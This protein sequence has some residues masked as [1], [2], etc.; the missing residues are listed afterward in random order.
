MGQWGEGAFAS[1]PPSGVTEAGP[2]GAEAHRLL[3]SLGPGLAPEAACRLAW[4]CSEL[5]PHRGLSSLRA[6][7][8]A[9]GSEGESLGCFLGLG[10]K[11][12]HV[13]PGAEGKLVQPLSPGRAVALSPGGPL[14]PVGLSGASFPPMLRASWTL[15]DPVRASSSSGRRREREDR[16]PT[17]RDS[18]QAQGLGRQQGRRGG[19]DVAAGRLH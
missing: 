13:G 4:G 6:R 11:G 9:V 5:P 3:L 14:G 8:P 7:L 16:P 2:R 19:K 10:E 12:C 18:R 15:S 1:G 17:R